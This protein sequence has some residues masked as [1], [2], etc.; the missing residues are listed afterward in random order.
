VYTYTYKKV[1]YFL[2]AIDDSFV[3]Q[4][5]TFPTRMNAT[6]DL[7]LSNEE[8]TVFDVRPLGSFST[9]DHD[10]IGFQL[11]SICHR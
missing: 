1:S 11:S 3:T 2:E 7:V 8:H 10:W 4:H 5:V 9:S 6:L